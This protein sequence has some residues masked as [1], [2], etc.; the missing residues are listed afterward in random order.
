MA[1]APAHAAAEATRD[2]RSRRRRLVAPVA[3]AA[4]VIAATAYIRAV[5]PN[6]PGHYPLC[7]TLALLGIDCPGCGGL[8]A[9]HALA[10]GDISAALDHNALFVVLAPVLVVTWALWL[11]RAWTGVT[12]PRTPLR[13]TVSRALPIA[14]LVI[15]MAFAVIRNFVPYLGSGA[16]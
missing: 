6:Q 3:T 10:H 4:G 13:Y 11:R 15:A 7:P 8:R 2:P 16:G 5:D 1:L 9:T 14:V 12:P